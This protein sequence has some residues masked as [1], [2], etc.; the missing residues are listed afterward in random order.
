MPSDP[1]A[2]PLP[3]VSPKRPATR[4]QR[5]S[6]DVSSLRSDLR[7]LESKI[8]GV[9]SRCDRLQQ[10]IQTAGP[11]ESV[12]LSDLRTEIQTLRSQVDEHRKQRDGMLEAVRQL[13]ARSLDRDAATESIASRLEKNSQR[14]TETLERQADLA[15][16]IDHLQT[17]IQNTIESINTMRAES[18]A[19]EVRRGREVAGRIVGLYIIGC[20]ALTVA[21]ATL[22]IV[23]TGAGIRQ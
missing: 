11:L 21:I 6:A 23:M 12:D 1:S 15:A 2:S 4:V 13:D 18:A 10:A 3:L 5:I 7:T 8:D 20:I 16:R 17:T 22:I 14:V 19:Q 9:Q